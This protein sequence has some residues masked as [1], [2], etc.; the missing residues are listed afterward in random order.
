MQ[1]T[2]SRYEGTLVNGR[3]EG[4]GKYFFPH[5]GCVYVG[6]FLDGQF[7]GQG[8]VYFPSLGKFSATWDHGVAVSGVYSSADG[9]IYDGPPE[10]WGYLTREDRRYY[11]E[12]LNGLQPAGQSQICNDVPRKIPDG[13]FDTGDGYL[14]R[15]L[16]LV[17]TYDDDFL[18]APDADEQEWV[19]MHTRRG[20]GPPTPPPPTRPD[21]ARTKNSNALALLRTA[22]EREAR[23]G[24]KNVRHPKEYRAREPAEVLRNMCV[25]A[26]KGDG[27]VYLGLFV[28]NDAEMATLGLL[29][30]LQNCVVAARGEQRKTLLAELQRIC[31][32]FGCNAD[33]IPRHVMKGESMAGKTD[34]VFSERTVASI[35]ALASALLAVLVQQPPLP[36]VT[37]D[38]SDIQI[39]GNTATGFLEGRVVRFVLGKLSCWG[40]VADLSFLS[41]W[42]PA[43]SQEK[44]IPDQ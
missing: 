16:G 2:S 34:L 18:R 25:A 42:N 40:L 20:G 43:A 24:V 13:M 15:E 30:A 26:H 17:Y 27:P 14:N 10:N 39:E 6:E 12:H 28:D 23:G 22:S 31:S 36:H 3:M 7:H 11:T 33:N 5:N 32:E 4:E 38:L 29:C 35:G 19:P 21:T 9:L 37:S 8:T 44:I 41:L 1:H